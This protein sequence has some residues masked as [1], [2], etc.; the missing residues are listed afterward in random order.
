MKSVYAGIAMVLFIASAQA[1]EFPTPLETESIGK[2][3]TLPQVYPKEWLFLHD[4]NF[5]SIIDG[6]IVVLDLTDTTN[7][8]KGMIGA[9]QMGALLQGTKSPELY[10]AETFYSRRTR[11]ERVDTITVYDT[12][13]L[14]YKDEIVL[15]GGKRGQ[16]VTQKNSFQFTDGERLGLV[17]N[18][19]PAASVTVVDLPAREVLNEIPLPGCS[20][21]YP[22][23]KR[24]FSTLCANGTMMTFNLDAQGK[25]SGRSTTAVFN[26]ID[27]DPLFMK[28]ALIDG[29][30]YFV[31]FQGRVQPVDLR[32]EK[33]QLAEA[34]SL[35]SDDDRKDNWR[36]GGWHVLSGDTDNKLYV[37]MQKDGQEG[38]HKNGGGEVWVFD[39]KKKKRVQR[40][41]LATHGISI[42]VTQGKKPYMAV[43]NANMEVDVYDLATAKVLQTIGGRAAETPFVMHAAR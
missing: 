5:F 15:Q 3:A 39:T 2:V 4:A 12:K 10:V 41:E 40:I 19:T 13:T 38:T 35:V 30:T 9:G 11:G 22:T 24:G 14:G 21:M 27:Q 17:Y 8:Y 6:K 25:E 34:W 37:L 42:E 20:L 31:S 28:T 32:G 18:F 1:A 36:P 16:F 23:G 26:T 7:P 43:V 29:L 33:A